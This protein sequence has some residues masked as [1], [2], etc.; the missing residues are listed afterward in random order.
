MKNTKQFDT[1]RNNFLRFNPLKV[2]SNNKNKFWTKFKIHN[3]KFMS[4]TIV[5]GKND[6]EC[7]S[8]RRGVVVN[9]TAQ[10]H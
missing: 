9:T 7:P 4:A 6:E 1:F 3:L 10:L 8:W 5:S 2:R